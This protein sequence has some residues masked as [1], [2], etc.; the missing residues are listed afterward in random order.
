[1]LE[2]PVVQILNLLIKHLDAKP[3]QIHS[4]FITVYFKNL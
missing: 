3:V 2:Q 4:D 1:M